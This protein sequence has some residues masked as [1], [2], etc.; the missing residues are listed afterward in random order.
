MGNT[1]GINTCGKLDSA[2]ANLQPILEMYHTYEIDNAERDGIFTRPDIA[3]PPE[4]LR[5]LT[6]LAAIL[7]E[8]RGL[9]HLS[10]VERDAYWEQC[11]KNTPDNVAPDHPVTYSFEEREQHK[12]QLETDISILKDLKL[13]VSKGE[14]ADNCYLHEFRHPLFKIKIGVDENNVVNGTAYYWKLTDGKYSEGLQNFL[15]IDLL[16]AVFCTLAEIPPTTTFIV[17]WQR[18]ALLQKYPGIEI[19]HYANQRNI[20]LTYNGFTVEF[21]YSRGKHLKVE[22]KDHGKQW[23]EQLIPQDLPPESMMAL[24]QLFQLFLTLREK[25]VQTYTKSA[26]EYIDEVRRSL[27]EYQPAVTHTYNEERQVLTILHP[28]ASVFIQLF[29][30]TR[31]IQPKYCVLRD[32]KFTKNPYKISIWNP[33]DFPVNILQNIDGTYVE[34]TEDTVSKN[35]FSDK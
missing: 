33:Y 10:K 14:V 4:L 22:V 18:K 23:P 29:P 17:D 20:D 30:S 5:I 27:D 7:V 34:P 11:K 9:T 24:I 15:D 31:M 2:P 13:L 12:K 21:Y 32:G 6:Y 35:I 28:R 19:K 1:S 26:E 8:R 16:T 25:V 3:I